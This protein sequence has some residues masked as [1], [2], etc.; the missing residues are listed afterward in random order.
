M[1]T[2]PQD[3]IALDEENENLPSS[4]LINKIVRPLIQ[5][6]RV[7]KESVHSDYTK[8]HLDYSRL[9]GITTTQQQVITKLESS[10][11]T[12]QKDVSTVLTNKISQNDRKISTCMEENK[13]L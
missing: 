8:L 9:E 7:L 6:M 10:I 13:Q 1:S 11:T 3:N 2:C 12:Q 4:E 5:E